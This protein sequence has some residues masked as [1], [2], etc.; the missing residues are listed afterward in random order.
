MRATECLFF[1]VSTRESS[2]RLQPGPIPSLHPT[3]AGPHPAYAIGVIACVFLVIY[4]T[5]LGLGSTPFF[6]R[7]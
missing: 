1:P 3:M 7:Q 6:Q 2:T 4:L 5:F